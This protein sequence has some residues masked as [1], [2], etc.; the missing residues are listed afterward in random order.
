MRRSVR[1]PRRDLLKIAFGAA[2]VGVLG[3]CAPAAPA[4]PTSAPPAA[5][6][7]EAPKPAAAPA[8]STPVTVAAPAA[9]AAPTQAAAAPTLAAQAAPAKPSGSVPKN[10]FT[11]AVRTDPPSIDPGVAADLP[12]RMAVIQA[13]EPLLRYEGKPPKVVPHLAE[14]ITAAD[15]GK[16][17]TVKLRPG[18]K[19]HDGSEVDAD[20][21]V[22]SIDRVLNMKKGA[23]GA[24]SA[25]IKPGDTRALDKQTVQFNLT[26]PSAIFPATL[27]FLFIVNPKVINANKQASGAYGA[28][29]DYGEQYLQTVD[30]GTGPYRLKG[31]TP[32]AQIDFE[33]FPDY[34][35]GWK[36]QQYG[37]FT[38]KI[39]PE[40]P[41]AG[42][43]LRQG[44]V[45]G[46]YEFYA[47]NIF[48]DL[49]SDPNVKVHSDL[50]VKPL[51][52]YMNNQKAPTDNPKFRQAV[53]YAFDYKQAI[54]GIMAT[55]PETARLPGSAAAD[56]LECQRQEP[57]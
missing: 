50:G 28:N 34:W 31:R 35:R 1:L 11:L 40:P 17:Y 4:Q 6:P 51:Y 53:A 15:G 33:A 44:Q 12:G 54:E 46:I 57:V 13:Y 24:F 36:D 10:A 16:T 27:P 32:N 2:A 29:G 45:D 30:A 42:L 23:A 7:T 3:A 19:F 39:V 48:D 22:Y 49:A 55:Q 5:K 26:G 25:L 21:V 47:A 14:S 20:A 43:L 56:G 41:T 8:T 37:T 52:I 18:V 38:Y 9:Q